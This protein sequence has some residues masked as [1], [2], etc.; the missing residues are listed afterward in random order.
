M[1]KPLTRT[2]E[3][4]MAMM[5][6]GK[7]I[8]TEKA[9]KGFYYKRMNVQCRHIDFCIYILRKK[10]YRI[11]THRRPKVGYAEYYIAKKDMDYNAKKFNEA[12]RVQDELKRQATAVLNRCLSD[13]SATAPLNSRFDIKELRNRY[14]SVAEKHYKTVHHMVKTMADA[15]APSFNLKPSD[16]F[17]PRRY[18]EIVDARQVLQYVLV[19]ECFFSL[20]KAGKETVIGSAA[21]STVVHSCSEI[22]NVSRTV[23]HVAAALNHAIGIARQHYS[24]QRYPCP[25]VTGLH[26]RAT[27]A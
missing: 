15:I 10:G 16:L 7:T 24:A 17:I 25:A 5:L 9:K 22:L 27:A 23:D 8:D 6:H 11:T 20:S 4:A 18:R 2:Q 14:G 1:K 12:M 13:E 19:K 26:A 3:A 21:H